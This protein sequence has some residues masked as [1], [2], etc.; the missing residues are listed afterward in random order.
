MLN[1][2]KIMQL[3]II[4]GVLI[5]SFSV[6]YHLVIFQEHSK[7]ELDDCLQQAKEKYNK[8]W[9]ADCRYL[10]EELDENGSCETLP[11]ESA[12]WL[13]EEYMQLMDKCFKQYP[14]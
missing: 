7:K 14:Q 8:Q 3:S 2:K 5:I 6:F 4:L 10:G 12:Y 13:R 11:T 1:L 9:K